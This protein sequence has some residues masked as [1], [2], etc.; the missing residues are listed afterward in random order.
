MEKKGLVKRKTAKT[1]KKNRNSLTPEGKK[2][3]KSKGAKLQSFLQEISQWLWHRK[4]RLIVIAAKKTQKAISQEGI[5]EGSNKPFKHVIQ[6][7]MFRKILKMIP[8]KVFECF[9]DVAFR[10]SSVGPQ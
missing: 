3:M 2:F 7:I 1:P 6:I 10:I 9:S 4:K 8:V 5:R